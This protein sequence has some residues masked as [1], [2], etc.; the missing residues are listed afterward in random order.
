M[1]G[2]A[3][4]MT[5]RPFPSTHVART[6]NRNERLTL[7]TGEECCRSE[8]ADRPAISHKRVARRE[9]TDRLAFPRGGLKSQTASVG[10][11]LHRLI[12]RYL[13]ECEDTTICSLEGLRAK[14]HFHSK[15]V[16]NDQD[17]FGCVRYPRDHD[18]STIAYTAELTEV[19]HREVVGFRAP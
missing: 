4:S 7:G 5:A 8:W 6:R 15:Q 11:M 14:P 16:T 2:R 12:C 19:S 13:R 1:H 10:L 17:C 3:N 18:R 9:L